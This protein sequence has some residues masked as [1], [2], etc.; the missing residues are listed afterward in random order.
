MR[1]VYTTWP[2]APT[3]AQAA[4]ILVRERLAA[5][6]NVMPG[7]ISFFFWEGEVQGEPEA[8]CIFKT[9]DERVDA[10]RQRLTELH[11]Y[12][13][14]AFVALEVDAARSSSPFLDWIEDATRVA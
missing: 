12:D 1:L 8:I 10:L 6:A 14:P 5:C 11:P 2:D 9:I 13:L 7:A 3:A 4:R